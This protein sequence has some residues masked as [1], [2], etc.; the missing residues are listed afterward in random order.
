M[1]TGC[2]AGSHVVGQNLNAYNILGLFE[3]FVPRFVKQYK[4]PAPDIIS[5]FG[6][7]TDEVRSGSYPA[8]EQCFTSGEEIRRL[9]PP[10]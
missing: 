1:T 3:T 8:P 4:S 5:G 2:S 7:F 9:Y 10:D 6:T